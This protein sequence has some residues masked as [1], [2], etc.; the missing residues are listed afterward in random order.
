MSNNQVVRPSKE[1]LKVIRTLSTR[2]TAVA[3]ATASPV[4]SPESNPS[5]PSLTISIIRGKIPNQIINR[6]DLEITGALPAPEAPA[7]EEQPPV[8]KYKPYKFC[9]GENFNSYQYSLVN[10]DKALPQ[11]FD[12]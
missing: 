1:Q 2:A 6:P 7:P 9:S 4:P 8:K 5:L 3:R 11:S 12:P 10:N